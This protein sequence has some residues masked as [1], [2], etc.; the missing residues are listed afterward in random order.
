LIIGVG[1]DMVE[2]SR[3]QSILEGAA[4]ERFMNR[5]LTP[6]ERALAAERKARLAEFTAGRF[7]AKEAVSKALGCGIG[8]IVG[9]QDMEIVPC[10]G[11]RP[12]CVLSAA[13]RQRLGIHTEEVRVHVSIT[14]TERTAAAYAVA[15]RLP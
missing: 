15:E 2:I 13:S 8:G 6:A 11:G 3:V 12:E 1:I 5:V 9:L 10:D 4:G 7:A 14:H